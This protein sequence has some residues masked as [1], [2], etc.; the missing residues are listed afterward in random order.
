MVLG[1][2][3]LYGKV[4]F[5]S[6]LTKKKRREIDFRNLIAQTLQE[7]MQVFVFSQS[8]PCNGSS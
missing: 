8:K 2:G 5:P 6:Y 3:L 7:D 1:A 4:I